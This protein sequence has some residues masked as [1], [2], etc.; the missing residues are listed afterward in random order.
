MKKKIVIVGSTGNLGSKLLRFTE[1]NNISVFATT[2]FINKK[3]LLYQKKKYKIKKSFVLNNDY[4]RKLFY[5]F[6]ETKIDIIYFLDYGSYSLK[7]LNHFLRFN[8][9]SVISVA[10]KELII[11][12]GSIL[13]TKIL[14]KK[15]IF[16]PLDSEHF[17][18]LNL[19]FNKNSI[20]KIYIT[21]SGGPFY[22][23][24]KINMSNVLTKNV[25]SH[26]KWQMGKNNLIDS[27]NFMNKI[28]EIYELSHIY[29]IPLSKIDFLICKEAYVHSIVKYNDQTISLNCFNNNML[30]TLIKPLS[31][32]YNFKLLKTDQKYLNIDNLKLNIPKDR[33]FKVFKFYKKMME[34]DHSKQILLMIIN[35]SAH[36]LYLSNKLNYNDIVDY[37]MTEINKH[38]VPNNLSSINSILKFISKINCYY[39][40]NV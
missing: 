13:Q 16:I 32:F 30:I 15:N 6:L 8:T 23:D 35:N 21:A 27:S 33:R 11:A 5:K 34:F 20:N 14:L 3:K 29:N 37:I 19:R 18:L 31:Y 22:F 24:K 36:K 28:L 12:G 25:L 17:S 40:T 9:K 1:K 7:Y 38:K 39:K 10:N 2:C 4:D 26:P